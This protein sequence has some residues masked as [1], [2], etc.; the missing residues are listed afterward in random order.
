MSPTPTTKQYPTMIFVAGPQGV[1]SA[2]SC[3]GRKGP[4]YP[5]F[6]SDY[7][8]AGPGGVTSF[9]PFFQLFH[10]TAGRSHSRS[11]HGGGARRSTFPF[12]YVFIFWELLSRRGHE[13]SSYTFSIFIFYSILMPDMLISFG[14]ILVNQKSTKDSLRKSHQGSFISKSAVATGQVVVLVD[15][16]SSSR[17]HNIMSCTFYCSTGETMERV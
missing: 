15:P 1:V 9:L 2:V 11:F 6:H 8:V 13:E 10:G 4:P 12:F 7:L 17:E 14:M 5:L 3:R 16:A